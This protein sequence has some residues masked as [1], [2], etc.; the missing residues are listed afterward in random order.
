MGG[1]GC[2]DKRVLRKPP[3]QGGVAGESLPPRPKEI[4][5]RRHHSFSFFVIF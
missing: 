2:K 4:F 5:S 3:S 1:D